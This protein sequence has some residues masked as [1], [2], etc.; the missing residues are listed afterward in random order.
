M[1]QEITQITLKGFTE[2][3][4]ILIRQYIENLKTTEVKNNMPLKIEQ[5]L[6]AEQE[7]FILES[8]LERIREQREA[9][10]DL[11]RECDE[12]EDEGLKAIREH[13][14]GF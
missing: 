9:R 8:G 11:I 1:K 5:E 4:L 3:Q 10:A 2:K 14:A 6:T 7:D 13:E 12:S